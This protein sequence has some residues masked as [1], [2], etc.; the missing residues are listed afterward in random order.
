[1]VNKTIQYH[2]EN[3]G[4]PVYLLL[5]DATKAFDKVSFKVLSDVL[6]GKNVCRKIVNLMYYRYMNQ[7]CCSKCYMTLLKVV[8]LLIYYLYIECHPPI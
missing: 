3:V 1:M 4:S 6:L 7:L 5:L 2:T 8:C